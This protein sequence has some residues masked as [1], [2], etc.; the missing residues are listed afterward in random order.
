MSVGWNC[1]RVLDGLMDRAGY[2]DVAWYIDTLA[3]QR[4]VSAFASPQNTQA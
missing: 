2:L 3:V 1:S 4:L